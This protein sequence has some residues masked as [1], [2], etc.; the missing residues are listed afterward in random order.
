[1]SAWDFVEHDPDAVPDPLVALAALD[2]LHAAM[3]R[4]RIDL[5]LLGPATADLDLALAGAV[6]LGL[7]RDDEAEARRAERDRLLERLLALAPDRQPLHGDAFPRNSLVT[8]RGVVWIDLEDACS[9]PAIW[10]QGVLL[11]R[12]QD[13]AVE[14]I[15]RGRGDGDA[16]DTAI[17]LRVIQADVWTILHA[18]RAAGHI[19]IPT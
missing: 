14:A 3:R 2:D 9:G 11:R 7:L 15:L 13:P 17:A 12:L 1:M 19:S 8:P 4:I 6:R 10:D 5:P 18:A 16:L